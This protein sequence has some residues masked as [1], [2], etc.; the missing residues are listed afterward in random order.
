MNKALRFVWL[1]LLVFV[2]GLASASTVAFH[3]NVETGSCTATKKDAMVFS[4]DSGDSQSAGNLSFSTTKAPADSKTIADL[5]TSSLRH[6]K[7]L[8]KEFSYFLM[9]CHQH[10]LRI[11]LLV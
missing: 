8:I 5:L 2:S 4:I 9:P 7:I 3:S 6:P 10:G 11:N 1:S